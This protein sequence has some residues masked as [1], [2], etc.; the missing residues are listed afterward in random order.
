MATETGNSEPSEQVSPSMKLPAELRLQIY[1][2]A[3][4]DI[5][6]FITPT[7]TTPKLE[8]PK[9]EL[10]GALALLHTNKKLRAE[11]RCELLTLVNAHREEVRAIAS[12]RSSEVNTAFK[13]LVDNGVDIEG[14]TFLRACTANNVVSAVDALHCAVLRWGFT[15]QEFP[16]I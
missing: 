1:A 5:V 6:H 11:S 16:W 3:L 8:G 12:L 13:L 15:H 2:L 14:T 10:R 4:K 7:P 9:P